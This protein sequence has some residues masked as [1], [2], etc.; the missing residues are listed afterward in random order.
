MR[1]ESNFSFVLFFFVCPFFFFDCSFVF[2][3]RDR[4]KIIISACISTKHRDVA[5]DGFHARL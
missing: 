1:V 3:A 4:A 2:L 5:S